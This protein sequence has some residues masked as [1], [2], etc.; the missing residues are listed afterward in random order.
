[1]NSFRPAD[2]TLS[3]ARSYSQKDSGTDSK[4]HKFKLALIFGHDSTA[5]RKSRICSS[6]VSLAWY[7]L[8]AS[9]KL[10]EQHLQTWLPLTVM[11][12]LTSILSSGVDTLKGFLTSPSSHTLDDLQYAMQK[13]LSKEEYDNLINHVNNYVQKLMDIKMKDEEMKRKELASVL[14]AKQIQLIVQIIKENFD[15]L[16]ERQKDA[17]NIKLSSQEMDELVATVTSKL[18][19]SFGHPVRLSNEQMLQVKT[20][21]AQSMTN[22]NDQ[23]SRLITENL[24]MEEFI[25]KIVKSSLFQGYFQE[26][27]SENLK[28]NNLDFE[29]LT[30]DLD[31]IK[32]IIASKLSASEQMQQ[33]L[34]ML[35]Q[36]QNDLLK[37]FEDHQLDVDQRLKALFQ[38]ISE[39]LSA[40]KD[41][42][43][44]QLNQQVKAILIEI[45][46]F[47]STSSTLNGSQLKDID[48]REWIHQ[49]FVAKSYLEQ[50][51]LEMSNATGSR[52]H[53]EMNRSS[54]LLMHAISEKLKSEILLAVER[55]QSENNALIDGQ[56]KN[57][58]SDEEIKNVVKSV[59]AV[60][61]AD[62]TGLV[63]FALESAGGQILSTRCTESYQTKSAQI[64]IFGIP[65]WYPTNTPRIAISPNVQPGECWA[66][67]GFPGFLVLKLN[68]M[69][70]VT[71][72]TLEHIPKSLSPSGRIESAPRNFTV[73]G[74]KDEK[75]QDP[76]LFG[77]YEYIDNNASLQYFPVLN[78]GI[79]QP[80]EIVEL[81][82]ESN[83]GQPLYT[84]LYRFR[85]HGKST[86]AEDGI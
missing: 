52:I 73:W 20:L 39:Q 24:N 77:E 63:D 44:S 48:L 23:N 12:G 43:F 59:L 19:A 33:S 29:D 83:H 8:D 16:I 79:R 36:S 57:A 32:K 14:S 71:G 22:I 41:E 11:T 65:L 76:V 74:L 21:I 80:Y 30:K 37:R 35:Q 68:S 49:V 42:H 70:Y 86:I 67:Q 6:V 4:Q 3:V 58:L 31:F 51:L 38:D 26:K 9:E 61:D 82:I 46:G 40:L 56:I 47:K 60:Y 5:F 7:S 84:C 13:S 75:D 72:F 2:K 28:K 64:S 17:A 27:F 69:V 10:I 55:K 45:L 15:A 1:M 25:D 81:R 78:K 18:K 34:N 53:E 66:F 54:A 62:K 85:V 50:R